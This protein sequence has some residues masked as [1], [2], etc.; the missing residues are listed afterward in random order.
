MSRIHACLL[1]ALA[2]LMVGCSRNYYGQRP[3]ALSPD[4]ARVPVQRAAPRDLPMFEGH[5]GR[6]ATWSDLMQGVAWAD[7]IVIGE[8]HDDP[9]AHTVQ[10]AVV[11][12]VMV[13]WPGSAV[14]LE[15]LE[16][17][18]QDT[19]EAWRADDLDTTAFVEATSS[20]D[21]AGKGSWAKFYQPTLDA[22][23]RHGG[24]VIA[25]NAPRKYVRMARLEGHAA[26][27]ALPEEEQDHF[28][29]AESLSATA[30][31]ERFAE[32]MRSHRGAELSDSDVEAVFR[33]QAMW[34]ATMARSIDEAL[35]A[36][37][38]KV[39]HLVGRFHSDFEGGTVLELR[40]RRPLTRILVLSCVQ[41]ESPTLDAGDL[42]RADLV[43]L[44]AP[45]PPETPEEEDSEPSVEEAPGETA[46]RD[47]VDDQASIL[48]SWFCFF[49]IL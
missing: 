32:E 36:G 13:N 2:M 12:A 34:D 17:H 18:E 6:V 19:V 27:R 47:E 25:A 9:E 42:G 31:Y 5:S 1:A 46:P 11:E 7:V 4:D 24:V 22:A 43:I 40:N 30:Y 16:R 33:A 45:P 49:A 39:V 21:W 29:I 15:M 3:Q 44:T 48:S 26:M 35:D 10:R 20:A 23:R 41:S 38:T 8:S 28:A 14:S 37:A